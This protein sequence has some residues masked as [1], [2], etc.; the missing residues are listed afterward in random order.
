MKVTIE[1]L[2]LALGTTLVLIPVIMMLIYRINL[3]KNLLYSLSRT[4]IQLLLVGIFLKYIFEWDNPLLNIAWLMMI[5]FAGASTVSSRSEID[6]KLILKPVFLGFSIA[7]I[8]STLFLGFLY[9]GGKDYFNARFII[10]ISGMLIGNSISTTIVGIRS[11]DTEIK[12]RK[13]LFEYYLI[14]NAN[15][16]EESKRLVKTALNNAFKPMLANISTI[17]LIWLPGTMTGQI[18]AGQSPIEAIKYQLLIVIGYFSTCFVATFISLMQARK[19][20]INE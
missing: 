15:I 8:I 16:D 20:M 4:T 19:S 9:F 2:N 11:L 12:L 13:N 17:G 18:I 6:K 10:P 1:W 7:F 3:V 14:A 5:I